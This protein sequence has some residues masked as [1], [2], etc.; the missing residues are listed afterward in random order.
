MRATLLVALLAAAAFASGAAAACVA[1][2]DGCKTCSLNGQRCKACET[3]WYNDDTG[4]GSPAY[5]LTKQFTCVKCEPQGENPQWCSSC[6]GNNPTKC[7]KCNDWEFSDPVY[8]TKQGTCARC[9]EGCS[10]CDDYSARCT[11]CNEGFYHD[12]SKGRCVPCTDTNCADCKRGPGKCT[13]CTPGSGKL[14][15]KCVDCTRFDKNCSSCDEAANICDNCHTG[16][17]VSH[18]KCKACRVANCWGCWANA[19][20]C[21][22][23][24]SGYT[25]S[26]DGKRCTKAA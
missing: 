4:E 23:C 11:A 7:I 14:H 20:R 21:Q 2:K 15:G 8:V 12:K 13:R 18:G 25:L 5:G 16:F 17:G 22:E 10:A 3:Y 1:G 9:P 26:K 24:A 19:N 6:D